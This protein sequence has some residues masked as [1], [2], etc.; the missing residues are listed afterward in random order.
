MTETIIVALIGFAGTLA[1]AFLGVLTTYRI[2]QLEKKWTS[3]IISRPG[4][5]CW[6][7]RSRWP[8]T[9]SRIWSTLCRRRKQ[10]EN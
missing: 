1:G 9:G 5:R 6:R 3:I 4:S 10:Y 8:T 2:E 7:S